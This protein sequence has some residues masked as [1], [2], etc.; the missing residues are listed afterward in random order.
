NATAFIDSANFAPGVAGAGSLENFYVELIGRSHLIA[1]CLKGTRTTHVQVCDA[2]CSY[3]EMQ[4]SGN[5]IKVGEASFS[6][7]PL[8]SQG[9]QIAIGSA[10]HAAAVIHTI[11]E[12]PGH[13][14]LA[15]EFY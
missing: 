9:V 1:G 11:L 13:D 5:S 10:L 15:R 14:A 6:I 4:L 8:S 7:D 2:T 3:S 12:R